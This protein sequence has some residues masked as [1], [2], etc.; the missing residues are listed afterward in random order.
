MRR[1]TRHCPRPRRITLRD[2]LTFRLGIGLVLAPPGQ[3]PIQKAM[4][5]AGLA[6]GPSAPAASPDAYMERLGRLPLIYPPGERWLYHTGSDVLGVLIARASGQPFEEFLRERI[7]APLGMKDTGFHVPPERIDR[8]PPSYASDSAGR[9]PAVR[10]EARGGAYARPPAFAS[11]GGGLVS[12]V[13]DYHAFCRMLLGQG[14]LGRA[15][16]LSR[17]SVELM[18]TDQLAPGQ[19]AGSEAVLGRNRGWGFGLAVVTRRDAIED[20]PGR[21]GWDGGRGTSA[22]SDPAE[23]LVGILMTQRHMDAPEPPAVFRDFWTSVY[24]AIND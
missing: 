19:K 5:E 16:I 4:D 21:F 20:T 12:T 8:L 11:G 14:R 22:W 24:Q 1:S 17:P 23:D 15:R 7:F 6:P 3:Y 13:D 18:T 2:L 9:G 10:D